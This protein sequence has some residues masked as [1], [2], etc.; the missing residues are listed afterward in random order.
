MRPW[1][2][3]AVRNGLPQRLGDA[4]KRL[5]LP[6]ALQRELG[7]VRPRLSGTW[8]LRVPPRVL[9]M[10]RSLTLGSVLNLK[11]DVFP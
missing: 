8:L 6:L 1:G 3:R 9:K 7:T 11:Q 4:G 5:L 10:V 2:G